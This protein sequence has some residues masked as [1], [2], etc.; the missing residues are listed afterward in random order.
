MNCNYLCNV[1]NLTKTLTVDVCTKNI[2]VRKIKE[3]LITFKSYVENEVHKCIEEFFNNGVIK[4]AV[5]DLIKI[6]ERYKLIYHFRIRNKNWLADF[7]KM[8]LNFLHPDSMVELKACDRF[9]NDRFNGVMVVA[10]KK[11]EANTS[12][13]Y[14]F[15]VYKDINEDEELLNRHNLDFSILVTSS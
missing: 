9:S 13:N 10:K 1:D 2:N 11:I 6:A 14:I 4:K 5:S 12:I 7:L 8:Y 15:G 3:R